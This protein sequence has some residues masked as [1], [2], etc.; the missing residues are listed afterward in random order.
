MS[1]RLALLVLALAACDSK[2]QKPAEPPNVN[3]QANTRVDAPRYQVA[4]AGDSAVMV[5]TQTGKTWQLV[6]P[7][8]GGK[9]SWDE[10]EK[11]SI[12]TVR[13]RRKS[14]GAVKLLTAAAAEKYLASP[15]FERVP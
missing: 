5:D 9:S 2:P 15:E 7:H 3:V 6:N 11:S 4:G 8:D 1:N 13:V 12:E 14:D 10:V